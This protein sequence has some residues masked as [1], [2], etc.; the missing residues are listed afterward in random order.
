MTIIALKKNN[1]SK[2]HR[3]YVPNEWSSQKCENKIT[4]QQV[5]DL[6]TAMNPTEV[7]SRITVADM[8]SVRKIARNT[9]KS[10]KRLN[11]TGWTENWIGIGKHL[12]TADRTVC[13]VDRL[14]LSPLM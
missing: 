1:D 2:E 9:F 3:K 6:S 7:K 4:E 8:K 5:S 11:Q 13:H 14:L 10:N 12:S